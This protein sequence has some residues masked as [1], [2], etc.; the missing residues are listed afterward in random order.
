M[1]RAE[2]CDCVG[3]F[4][5]LAFVAGFVTLASCESRAPA[6]RAGL[7]VGLSS[8][9]T[10]WIAPVGDSV[11]LLWRKS[12]LLVPRDDGFWWVGT[13]E[14]CSV[15]ESSADGDVTQTQKLLQRR[16]ATYAARAG[17]DAVVA[18][19]GI[20]CRE[21]VRDVPGADTSGASSP[22][23]ECSLDMREITFVSAFALSVEK[24]Y[25]VTEHCDPA[26]YYTSGS[27]HVTAIDRESQVRLRPLLADSAWQFLVAQLAREEGCGVGARLVDEEFEAAWS[28]RHQAGA[29]RATFW[30]D[31]KWSREIPQ[32]VPPPVRYRPTPTP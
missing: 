32:L 9:T 8:G 14:R 25:T 24:R 10:L 28:V 13:A 5:R 18:L 20:S 23:T 3:L 2:L 4:H 15:T 1:R 17:T 16:Q 7:L 6:E 22:G 29:W 27:N 12:P 31:A 11:H 26:K 21:A 30:A 19:D